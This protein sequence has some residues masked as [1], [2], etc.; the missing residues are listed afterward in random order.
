M[1]GPDA[2][3]SEIRRNA[4]APATTPEPRASP[5]EPIDV[6]PSVYPALF[7][8][9]DD[10]SRR[11][12]EGH[13]RLVGAQLLLLLLAAL[14]SLSYPILQPI[15]IQWER[16]IAA[17]FLALAI[18]VKLAIRLR[19]FDGQWFDGRAVA[20]TV[21]T[22]TWRYAM[23]I[24]PFDGPDERADER[25][26]RT[27]IDALDSRRDLA[28]HLAPTT[29]EATQITPWMRR[30]R[31]A[32][33]PTRKAVYV[34][35]RVTDQIDWYTGKSHANRRAALRWFWVGFA[36]EAAALLVAIGI[37][38]AVDAPDVVGL[39]ATVSVAATAWTQFGRNDELCKSYMLA[40]NEL[41]RLRVL[42]E[43]AETEAKLAEIVAST[44]AAI[45]R[46]HTM[47][48]AKRG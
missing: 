43:G 26:L 12:R 1:G 15:S 6:G 19:A 42:L 25:F 11:G 47:W 46:E 21:K 41:L 27:I 20:E 2:T 29:R 33:F 40:A 44:E 31:A 13:T 5:S 28:M 35:E 23:R 39:L 24:S 36:F 14:L 16:A 10:A 7:V 8:S 22:A 30:L 4:A 9:A 18:V 37:V 48:M 3:A 45:S 38:A 34:A 32:P 17:A